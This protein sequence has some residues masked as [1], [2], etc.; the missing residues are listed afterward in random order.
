MVLSE[1]NKT[2]STVGYVRSHM[3]TA[4]LSVQLAA[5]VISSY[6]VPGLIFAIG[7]L[8]L[9]VN[10]MKVFDFQLFDQIVVITFITHGCLGLL[11]G[12]FWYGVFIC[13]N[14][15]KVPDSFTPILALMCSFTV[16]LIW[17][18]ARNLGVIVNLSRSNGFGDL[19]YID[20]MGYLAGTLGAVLA[21]LSV[22]LINVGYS[23]ERQSERI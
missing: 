9:L 19:P 3:H 2:S 4:P 11:G 6:C 7:R 16:P 5:V 21:M 13:L 23:L 20:G 17:G 10:Q 1:I 14:R 18:S 15:L 8:V 22:P 12:C